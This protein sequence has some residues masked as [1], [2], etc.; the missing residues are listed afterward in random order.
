MS[1]VN[2]DI[3]DNKMYISLHILPVHAQYLCI[4]IYALLDSPE[5]LGR[6]H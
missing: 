4:Y 2:N 1:A 5:I 3:S 6:A